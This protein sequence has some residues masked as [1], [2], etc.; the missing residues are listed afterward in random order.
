METT[1]PEPTGSPT[2]PISPNTN[3]SV[4]SNAAPPLVTVAAVAN[5]TLL[6]VNW[7]PDPPPLPTVVS[8]TDSTSPI[9]YPDQAKDIA[10][11]LA[12]PVL[13]ELN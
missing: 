12:I 7:N 5:P 10:V 4:A 13:F 3:V 1:N 11:T 8:S 2:P 6:T 9:L